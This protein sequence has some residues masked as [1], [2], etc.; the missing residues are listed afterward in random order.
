MNGFYSHR[1]IHKYTW[2]QHTRNLR[3]IIDYLIVRQTSNLNVNDVR[4][5]K[6]VTCGS[7]HYLVKGIIHFPMNKGNHRNPKTMEST[8]ETSKQEVYN[9][10]SLSQDSV[11]YLYNRR[12]DQKLGN[13]KPDK[14]KERDIIQCM[15][16]AAAEAVGKREKQKSNKQWWTKEIE[17]KIQDKIDKYLDREI[18]EKS[19]REVRNLINYNKNLQWD[20]KCREINTYIGGS[21]S[22]EAWN[23]VKTLKTNETGHALIQIIPT[24]EWVKY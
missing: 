14:N 8:T 15:K 18:Y 12:L 10:G 16:E 11:K 13:M 9:V 4:V 20:N 2:V 23:F 3:S 1:D 5:H 7:D 6:G 22:S 17:T 21:K 19:K 24:Q